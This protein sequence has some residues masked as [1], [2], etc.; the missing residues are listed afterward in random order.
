MGLDA[1]Q[2][3]QVSCKSDGS[4]VTQADIAIEN[5]FIRELEDS[6]AG[7]YVFGEETI[8][9]RGEEFAASALQ[10]TTYVVD[11]IDGTSPYSHRLPIWG[12]SLGCARNGVL[13]EGAIYMPAFGDLFFS[14]GGEVYYMKAENR[15]VSSAV[16][17]DHEFVEFSPTGII[18]ITQDAARRG[19]MHWPNPV[20]ALVCAVMPLAYML[21]GKYMAYM[22]YLNLWDLA[23]GL[24]M[25]LKKG[26]KATLLDGTIVDGRITADVYHLEEGHPNRWKAHCPCLFGPPGMAHHLIDKIEV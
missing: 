22:G 12:V 3:L 2:K 10:S 14:D 16:P 17:I 9:C 1:Q 4:V 21:Q 18:A 20:Q 8:G 5:F 13:C 15:H 25:L 7:R 24:P 19:R 23:G 6:T 26:Y 11:P